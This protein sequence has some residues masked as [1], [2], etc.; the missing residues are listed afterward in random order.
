MVANVPWQKEGSRRITPEDDRYALVE[1]AV[2]DVAGLVA[3]RDEIDRGGDSY[4]AD[5]LKSMSDEFSGAELFTIVG[6]D[7]AA[8]FTTWDR[9]EEVAARSQLVVV[10]RPGESVEV[11]DE[12]DW[13]R[14]E[15]PHL[16]VSSTDLRA[17]FVDGRPL[18]YL[19]TEPV[20]DVIRRRRLYEAGS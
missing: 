18:D 6:D 13:L 4:T 8:G 2:A 7:A 17:R 5:T 15:V 9:Y 14:V 12:F 11:P 19:I 1:A 3:G 16:E 20:L 10:D